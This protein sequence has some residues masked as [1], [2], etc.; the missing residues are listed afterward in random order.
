MFKDAL[1]DVVSSIEIALP[2]IEKHAPAIAT[3]LAMPH[4]A[5]IHYT[6][7]A[8]SML[9]SAFNLKMPDEIAKLPDILATNPDIETKLA[10]VENSFK[11]LTAQRWNEAFM[12]LKSAEVNVKV[13]FDTATPPASC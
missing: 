2:I 7:L 11:S 9:A 1:K 4:L 8:L 5:G 12:R 10:S 13:E 3:A 6:Y